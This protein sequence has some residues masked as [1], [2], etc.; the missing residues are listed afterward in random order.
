MDTISHASI[1]GGVFMVYQIFNYKCA[2]EVRKIHS[3]HDDKNFEFISY[4]SHVTEELSS[5]AVVIR[6]RGHGDENK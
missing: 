6:G 5:L 2:G 3:T 4:A 1:D